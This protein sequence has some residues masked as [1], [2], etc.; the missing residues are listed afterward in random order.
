MVWSLPKE[1]SADGLNILGYLATHVGRSVLLAPKKLRVAKAERVRFGW[2]HL[3]TRE[4]ATGAPDL[5]SGSAPQLHDL[6]HS[7]DSRLRQSIKRYVPAH[8]L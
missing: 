1:Q 4:N 5:I 2:L 6:T 3:T 7:C 8:A